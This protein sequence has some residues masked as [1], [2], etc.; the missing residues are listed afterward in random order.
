MHCQLLAVELHLILRLVVATTYDNLCKH[1]IATQFVCQ[2]FCYLIGL[3]KVVTI[4]LEC[5][6]ALSTH[7]LLTCRDVASCNLGEQFYVG[8]HLVTNLVN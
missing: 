6:S 4:N 3:V 5:G 7:S 8:T 1:L 2:L